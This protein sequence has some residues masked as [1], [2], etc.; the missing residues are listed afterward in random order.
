MTWLYRRAV[1]HDNSPLSGWQV[2]YYVPT[3]GG[4]VNWVTTSR[5]ETADEARTEVHYLNGG[6]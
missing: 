5:H 4:S 6:S 1:N 2:G 3:H